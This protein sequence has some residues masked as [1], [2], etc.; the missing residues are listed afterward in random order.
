MTNSLD[1]SGVSSVIS[2]RVPDFV[3]RE[4]Q[5][6]SESNHIT[7][8]ANISKI[9]IQ[10][11]E[12]NQFV[13][14]SGFI[15]SNRSFL[16]EILNLVEMKDI[17]RISQQYCVESLK[18]SIM[19]IH[20]EINK[21]TLIKTLESW[22]RTSYIPFRHIEKNGN[23]KYV[24]QHGLGEKWSRYLSVVIESIAHEIRCNVEAL[25]ENDMLT[26]SIFK[27]IDGF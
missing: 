22:L 8:N 4:L 26:F 16:K 5:Q 11:V 7:I 24:V 19:F 15:Y 17:R 3:K 13:G 20:G 6:I 12:W 21:N 23:S 27:K 10:Y 1:N 2:I 9:L 14:D 18:T 25:P